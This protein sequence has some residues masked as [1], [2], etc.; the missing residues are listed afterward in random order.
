MIRSEEWSSHRD[1]SIRRVLVRLLPHPGPGAGEAVVERRLG[2]S[3]RARARR[4][5][6]EHRAADVA[7]PRAS[8]PRRVRRRRRPGARRGAA[9]RSSSRA[10]VPM[11]N[12]PP[13][14]PDGREQRVDDVAD[15][16]EVA[17]LAAVAEDRSSRRRAPSAR[18]RS[19]RRRPRGPSPGAG[20]RRS[21]S[22]ARRGCEPW[23]RF[24]PAR[25][26]SPHFF[27]MPYGDSGRN[28]K[29][30]VDR[31]RGTRRSR[32]RRRTRRSP[33]RPRPARPG[34]RSRCRRR[35]PRRRT[36]AASSTSGRR[37]GRRG[38]R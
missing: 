8:S 2:A 10:P 4:A 21:R 17:H 35:S 6:V 36:R 20:R 37:P 34:A 19:R 15:V 18:G 28:G 16:D 22:A 33:A 9:R 7:E 24:Q 12:G 29:S 23:I 14:V 31:A 27:A 3:S 38:G 5:G 25:Y 26:S 13:A 30:L 32:R 11:L 1:P